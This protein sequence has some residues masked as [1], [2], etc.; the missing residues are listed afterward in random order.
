MQQETTR[1]G[2]EKK[3]G[4]ANGALPLNK[5]KALT[6]IL[7]SLVTKPPEPVDKFVGIKD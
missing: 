7:V 6:L 4:I 3:K 5:G 2:L 1:V